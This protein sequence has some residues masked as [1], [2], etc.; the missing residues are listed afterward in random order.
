MVPAPSHS[1]TSLTSPFSDDVR[2]QA[3]LE[4]LR[5][6]DNEEEEEV[7]FDDDDYSDDDSEASLTLISIT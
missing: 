4:R 1:L 5:P 7:Y 3:E 2:R 6:G